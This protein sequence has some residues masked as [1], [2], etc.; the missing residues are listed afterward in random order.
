MR[1]KEQLSN[2]Q[3]VLDTSGGLIWLELWP[4][5]APNHVRNFLDLCSTG[6]YDGVPFHRVMPGFMIQGGR[7]KD[8]KPIRTVDAEFSNRPHEA[9]VLSAARLSTDINSASSEFFIVHQSSRQLDGKY[10]AF[11]RVIVGMTAVE[12]IVRGAEVTV[13]RRRHEPLV[14]GRRPALGSDRPPPVTGVPPCPSTTAS[15]PSTTR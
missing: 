1:P 15:P 13:F 9:G 4:D 2:Y 10:S 7:A 5:V 3:V 8:G 12:K 11:G 14:L 6:Y